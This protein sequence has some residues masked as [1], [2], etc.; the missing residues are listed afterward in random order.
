MI[1]LY[2]AEGEGGRGIAE[3]WVGSAASIERPTSS[4][5]GSRSSA[6]VSGSKASLTRVCSRSR[7]KRAVCCSSRDASPLSAMRAAI[8]NR[9]PALSPIATISASLSF[10]V[11]SSAFSYLA[12]PP[13]AVHAAP[14]CHRQPRSLP[15]RLPRCL[16]R[17]NPCRTSR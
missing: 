11:L 9:D 5:G 4:Y 16:S 13:R 6:Y 3:A 1:S 14:P 8:A 2:C 15:A 7:R 12:Q 17:R 10:L